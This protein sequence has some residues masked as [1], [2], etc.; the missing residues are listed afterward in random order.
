MTLDIKQAIIIH[1]ESKEPILC[2]IKNN[3]VDNFFSVELLNELSLNISKGDPIVVG[4]LV[5]NNIEAL[6][7][8]VVNIIL[9]DGIVKSLIIVADKKSVPIE[10]RINIR[11]PTSIYGV[12]SV[13]NMVVAEVCIKDISNSGIRIYTNTEFSIGEL[14]EIDLFLLNEV[15]HFK[16]SIVRKSHRYDKKEYGLKIEHDND[17]TELINKFIELICD[18]HKTLISGLLQNNL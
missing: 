3:N 12:V 9:N 16:C 2:S 11:I 17:S 7:G 6:G 5:N 14:F 8:S 10:R 18:Y 1:F 4:M 13:S 15:A